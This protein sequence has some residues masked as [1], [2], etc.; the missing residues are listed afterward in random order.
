MKVS[1]FT[2]LK[3]PDIDNNLLFIE[4]C[5]ENKKLI[6]H[7]TYD[8][9]TSDINVHLNS[10][11]FPFEIEIDEFTKLLEKLKADLKDWA[12]RVADPL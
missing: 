4:V 5:D 9:K 3:G 12:I 7:V 6:F 11:H 10:H 2:F 1:N 8:E